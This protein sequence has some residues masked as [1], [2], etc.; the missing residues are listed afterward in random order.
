MK[1][2]STAFGVVMV[3]A[4]GLEGG[5]AV[6][7]VLAAGLAAVAAG[8]LDRRVAVGAVL[9]TIV[10]L[11]IGEPTPLYAAVSGLAAATYLVTRYGDATGAATLTVPTVA[12]L[13]GFTMVGLAA[14]AITTKITWVPLLAP[15]V[16]TGVLVV[17]AIPLL[18]GNAIRP[19]GDV[20]PTD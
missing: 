5:S 3:L 2:V 7:A 9:L 12:G 16:M 14:T 15:V 17:V 19:A 6:L 10:G 13:L 4:A 1:G 18:G 20:D 11:A 8:L